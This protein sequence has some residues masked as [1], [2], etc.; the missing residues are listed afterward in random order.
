MNQIQSVTRRFLKGAVAG[1]ILAIGKVT[2]VQPSSWSDFNLILMNLGI[3]G[4]YGFVIGLI[5]AAEK[6]A[7]WDDTPTL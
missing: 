2:I 5:L 4:T 6:W 7:N 3:A 1:A